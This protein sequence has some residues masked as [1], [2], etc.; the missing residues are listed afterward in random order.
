MVQEEWNTD[1]RMFT[2]WSKYVK[3]KEYGAWNKISTMTAL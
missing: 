2:V 1:S 3:K